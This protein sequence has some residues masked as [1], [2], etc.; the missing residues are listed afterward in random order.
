MSH[1]VATPTAAHQTL[2]VGRILTFMF[3]ESIQRKCNVGRFAGL[4]RSA[5]GRH[6]EGLGIA[7]RRARTSLILVV[8]VRALSFGDCSAALPIHIR[9]DQAFIFVVVG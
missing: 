4:G 9:Y 6:E 8:V 3:K 5:A 2:S 7:R 1:E